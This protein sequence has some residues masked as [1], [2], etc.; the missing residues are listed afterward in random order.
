[1]EYDHQNDVIKKVFQG[2]NERLKELTCLYNVF[3]VLKDDLRPLEEVLYEV[4]SKIPAGW[5]YPSVCQP[6]IIYEGEAFVM[7]GFRETSWK[8]KAELVA[9]NKIVG[10][11]EVF[12]TQLIRE[13]N[14]SQFLPEEQ[15]LLNTIAWKLSDHIFS[16]RLQK[17]ISILQKQKEL[18]AYSGDHLLDGSPDEHSLWRMRMA[19][20]I[21]ARLDMNKYGV[22]G[23]YLIGSARDGNAGP[24][25]DID[26]IVLHHSSE[27]QFCQLRAF[28]E[29]WSFCL[30]EINFDRTGYRTEG[31]L[32]V[33]YITER[34]IREQTSYAS[35]IGDRSHPAKV[36]WEQK[37]TSEPE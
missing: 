16:R 23:I 28:L 12:Y 18:Q 9:D 29:G 6:R 36:L 1:M 27:K 15:K 19:E 5:Q 10:C 31:L 30:A 13:V 32:D 11:I 17:S 14:N 4:I 25:S 26:L 8:Q 33:H 20:L 21:V 24:A 7:P 34:D 35:M 3:E 22:R 2:I 37:S